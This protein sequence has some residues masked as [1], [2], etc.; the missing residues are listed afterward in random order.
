MELRT[1]RFRVNR[2]PRDQWLRCSLPAAAKRNPG[3][4][5]GAFISAPLPIL[6]AQVQASIQYP[7][8]PQQTA[9]VP[10]PVVYAGPALNYVAGVLEVSVQIPPL[11]GFVQRSSGPATIL[12]IAVDGAADS[13]VVAV[14]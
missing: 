5:D 6:L 13:T 2:R 9:V 10:A 12:T 4:V 14:Q 11:P 8:G 7:T 1:A 3:G